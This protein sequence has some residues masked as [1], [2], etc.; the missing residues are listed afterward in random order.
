MPDCDEV[1]RGCCYAEPLFWRL[2]L[3]SHPGLLSTSLVA[4]FLPATC[5]FLQVPDDRACGADNIRRHR[6]PL[7]YHRRAPADNCGQPS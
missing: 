4:G 1:R 2:L 7:E 6:W 3:D 5:R